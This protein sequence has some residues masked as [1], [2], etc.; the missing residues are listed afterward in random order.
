MKSFLK[1]TTVGAALSGASTAG[2][3]AHKSDQSA[4]SKLNIVFDMD[5]TLLHTKK[6]SYWSDHNNSNAATPDFPANEGGRNI[7]LRPFVPALLPVLA[8]FNNIY[9]FTR[10]AQPYADAVLDTSGLDKYIVAKKYSEECRGLKKDVRLFNLDPAKSMLVD[11]K[12]SNAEPGQN[13]YHIP[14][15]LPY[16]TGDIEFLKLF[17]HVLKWNIEEDLKK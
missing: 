13:L 11:D 17:F 12:L 14:K 16:L 8:K 4:E 5:E 10:G 3:I 7:W 2:Y 6:Q 15:Y 9:I 1:F